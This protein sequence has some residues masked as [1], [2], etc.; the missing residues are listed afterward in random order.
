MTELF[1]T[2]TSV[3][4]KGAARAFHAV[5]IIVLFASL[6]TSCER[7][8]EWRQT[9]TDWLEKNQDFDFSAR[10]LSALRQGR[11]PSD[12]LSYMDV[13]AE[14]FNQRT[15]NV[16]VATDCFPMH[17]S[18]LG[19]VGVWYLYCS[20]KAYER[21]GTG[22]TITKSF[23]VSNEL[24]R[25]FNFWRRVYSLWSKDQYVIHSSAYPEVVFEMLD[26]SQVT[27]MSERDKSKLA[28]KVA[29]DHR[30]NY[31]KLL[32]VLHKN[33]KKPVTELSPALRRIAD[34]MAHIKDPKKYEIAAYSL[35]SQRGQRE[36]IAKGVA[37]SGRYL[38]HA[39]ELFADEGIPEDLANLA[40]VESSFNLDALSNVGASGV[41]QV[42]PET[43]KQYMIVTPDLDERSDPIKASRAAAKLLRMNYE[44]T[45]DWALAITAYNHGVGGIR[46]AVR[47]TR[48]VDLVHLI[49][50]YQSKQFQFASKNFYTEFL[51]ALATV[52]DADRLFPEVRRAEPLSFITV[53]LK[54]DMTVSEARA[55]FKV[56]VTDL[57][58]YNPD[59]SWRLIKKNGTLP[60]RYSLKLPALPVDKARAMASAA[61]R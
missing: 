24:A 44:L 37:V 12:D 28:E 33:R 13:W 54:S 3:A 43:G 2:K 46:N 42:M 31:K 7:P 26:V 57:R 6:N 58:L 52:E 4:A 40:F 8:R 21:D 18:Q 10:A 30:K 50:K 39:K 32:L 9:A 16:Q 17:V 36:F 11:M 1:Y 41:Y 14:D 35:R 59:I 34:Q 51:A 22:V 25:R 56:S 49:E 19:Q 15:R 5:L 45:G 38:R 61:M 48:S 47:K 53:R 55:K 20:P 23:S 60:R 27:G 29:R